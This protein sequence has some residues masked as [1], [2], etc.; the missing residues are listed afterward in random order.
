MTRFKAVIDVLATILLIV[1]ACVVIWRQFA[2]PSSPQQRTR[3]E[4]ATGSLPSDLMANHRG[5]GPV[6]LIEFADF[7]CPFCG[8]HV[9]ETEPTIRKAFVD[10]GVLRQVFVNFPLPNHPRAKPAS[11]AAICAGNQGKFWEMHDGLFQNQSALEEDD[12]I[13][14]AREIGV[15]SELFLAC[16][17]SGA[18][19]SV[20]ERHTAAG[21]ELD[22]RATPSF[23]LGIVQADGSVQLKTRING[24]LAFSEFR[25]A[26]SDITPDSVRPLIRPVALHWLA[27]VDIVR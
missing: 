7:Q 8:K 25:S 6:A 12:L 21:R 19:R 16:I 2:A 27:S 3:I 11:E 14:R 23:F 9:R 24:A 17:A 20:V 13:K 10:S 15:D 1:A 22:V 18:A 4:T 5:R 26:I